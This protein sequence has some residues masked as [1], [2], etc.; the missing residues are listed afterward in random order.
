MELV[1]FFIVVIAAGLGTMLYRMNDKPPVNPLSA[2]P[3]PV[4]P[5]PPQPPRRVEALPAQKP[6]RGQTEAGIKKAVRE[7]CARGFFPE[8]TPLELRRLSSALQKTEFNQ[9]DFVRDTLKVLPVW[10]GEEKMAL[11]HSTVQSLTSAAIGYRTSLDPDIL[12]EFPAQR[13]VVEV[14]DAADVPGWPAR[15]Q[16][17]GGSLRNGQMVALKSDPI[18]R[19]IS[20]AGLPFP[21]FVV[22]SGMGVDDVDRAEAE[23]L[24]LC[25][26]HDKI[27]PPPPPVIDSADLAARLSAH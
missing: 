5:A 20:F 26:R 21:P 17:A 12:G 11:L 6:G 2:E 18:W 23:A 7:G 9:R 27:I 22:G 13:L 24:G 16:A 8:A 25:G 4:P 3:P 15:W 10:P 19:R 14:D 1:I